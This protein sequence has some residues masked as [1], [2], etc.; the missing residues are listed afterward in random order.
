MGLLRDP[1]LVASFSTLAGAPPSQPSRYPFADRV[2]AA[3]KAGF[4]GI[5]L[6]VDDA[7]RVR[8][9]GCSNRAMLDVLARHGVRV[10]DLQGVTSWPS[11]GRHPSARRADE[12]RVYALAD[13]FGSRMFSVCVVCAAGEMP[14]VEA[15][16][17]RFAA[18]CDRAAEHGLTV[19]LEPIVLGGLTHVT[20]AA[21]VITRA[22]RPNG[23]VTVDLYHVFRAGSAGR[24][25]FA[26]LSAEQV[27]AVHL[28]DAA[29]EPQGSLADDCF[30]HRRIP[31]E[32]AAPLADRL[33]DL[34]AMGVDVPVSVEIHSDE[35]RALGVEDAA[36]RA[37]RGTRAVI[38]EACAASA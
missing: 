14:T 23:G 22:G 32:G 38:A 3:A 6:S 33:V 1:E 30:H 7:E 28:A 24:A 12:D 37:A 27:C 15:M 35:L 2:A 19:G 34:H 31:G 13:V 20:Q 10:T 17:E 11:D 29:A 8:A 25:P 26:G 18:V 4:R 16:A 5:G 21:E 9:G 36:M